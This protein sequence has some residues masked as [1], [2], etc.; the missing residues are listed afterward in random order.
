MMM[1][2]LECFLPRDP[3]ALWTV[4]CQAVLSDI[5]ENENYN[6]K[7]KDCC[8]EI[9]FNNKEMKLFPNQMQREMRSKFI[10]QFYLI[11]AK[12]ISR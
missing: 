8:R 7:M 4:A 1:M 6:L 9:C 10:S 2:E 3:G 5:N 12:M 11:A